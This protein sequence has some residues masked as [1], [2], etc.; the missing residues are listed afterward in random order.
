MDF[1]I[2]IFK[3]NINQ[4][5]CNVI[6]LS[7][8]TRERTDSFLQS[9]SNNRYYI[10]KVYD[11]LLSDYRYVVYLN[12]DNI[13]QGETVE[14]LLRQLSDNGFTIANPYGLKLLPAALSQTDYK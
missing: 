5:P 3:R 13:V 14:D 7:Q 4:V 11:K 2:L 10:Y 12:V 9:Y 1:K 8:E 6:Q